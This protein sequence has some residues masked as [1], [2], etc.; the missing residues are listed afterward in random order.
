MVT[1]ADV[2]D[3]LRRPQALVPLKSL[4]GETRN[5]V[6]DFIHIEPLRDRSEV[7]DWSIDAH[8]HAG[9]HQ[10]VLLFSGRV[11]VALDEQ[12]HD[13]SAPG[14][15]A[16]PASV[17]H[18]FEYEPQSSGFMLTIAD[19]QV[20]GSPIGVWQRS[21]LFERGVILPLEGEGA[22]VERLGVLAGEIF[23]EQE[24]IDTGRA[25]SIDWLTRTVLVILARE[26]DR[27]HEPTQGGSG[28]SD[29]FRDFRNL[30]EAH[31]AEHWAV[32]RYASE[33][34]LSESSLN[35]LCQSM[36]GST[37]FEIIQDRLELEARRRL[38]YTNAPIHRLAVD[39]G[40][41]DPSYFARFFRRRAGMS[42]RQFRA[43][44]Q[45]MV[46]ALAE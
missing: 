2:S 10:V 24:G 20:D 22:V 29:L 39:L 13:V 36:F 3:Q 23:R 18:S 46:G 19:A 31:H 9:L 45:T 12:T 28:S 40:F 8:S 25:A 17:V 44:H 1:S 42:P 30:V 21:R 14:A 15:I 5:T 37:A 16:I 35:R 6:V 34:H 26:S 27:F 4:F 7:F 32:K 38:V 11:R 33:L 43:E 41:A